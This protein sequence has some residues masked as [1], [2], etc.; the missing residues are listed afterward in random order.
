MSADV[1]TLL[2]QVELLEKSVETV[3]YVLGRPVTAGP[4]AVL[5]GDE[6]STAEFTMKA[7]IHRLQEVENMMYQI[8]DS[9]ERINA[10]MGAS[11]PIPVDEKACA[12]T[13]RYCR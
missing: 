11:G 13:A 2:E 10:L 8:R 7:L 12:S 1:R 9:V 3:Y 5:T 6:F 4:L